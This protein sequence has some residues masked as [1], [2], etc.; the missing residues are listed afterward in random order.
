M[1]AE[2][3]LIVDIYIYIYRFFF[4]LSIEQSKIKFLTGPAPGGD[5]VTSIAEGSLDFG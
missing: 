1:K 5:R 2:S 3:A 4:L